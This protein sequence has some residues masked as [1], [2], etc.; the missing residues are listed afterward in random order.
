V[1]SPLSIG[2]TLA[3]GFAGAA[4]ETQRKWRAPLGFD[5]PRPDLFEAN[6]DLLRHY[7]ES[8]APEGF[9]LRLANA[10]VLTQHGD[11]VAKSFRDLLR[12]ASPRRSLKAT[13]AR[14]SMGRTEDGRQDRTRSQRPAARRHRRA[15]QRRLFQGA[16]GGGFQ[17]T[18]TSDGRFFLSEKRS[19]VFEEERIDVK[20][21][22]ASATLSL[23][24]GGLSGGAAA[25]QAP[26]LG[27]II[28][29]PT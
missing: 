10:L 19:S 11:A 17:I 20:M 26:S 8:D 5:A 24:E 6:S 12:T 4:G 22:H 21:M 29:L 27:M 15:R 23:Y 2:M 3:M 13:S 18:S 16:L 28:V 7:G 14:Q 1:I 25:L 9:R